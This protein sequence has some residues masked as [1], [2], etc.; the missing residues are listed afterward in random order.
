MHIIEKRASHPKAEIEKKS[1]EAVMHLA[2]LRVWQ[3]AKVVMLYAATPTE[4]QTKLLI[5]RALSEG[6]KV[7]LPVMGEEGNA[8]VLARVED[9][10]RNNKNFLE[11]PKESSIKADLKKIDLVVV[12]GV[13]FDTQGN[14]LGRGL[15]YYDN[16]LKKVTAPCV[17]LAF[18]FQIVDRVPTQ[19]HDVPVKMIVTE[20]RMIDCRME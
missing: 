8:Y 5:A 11:P 13:A 10:V 7:C 4:V 16:F 15:G 14:R 17:G 2:S 20:S 12:P 3:R 1:A 6:K 18:E 19:E 9:L